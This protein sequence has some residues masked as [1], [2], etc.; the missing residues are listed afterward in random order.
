MDNAN[1][2]DKVARSVRRAVRFLREGV[3][4]DIGTHVSAPHDVLQVPRVRVYR[5][6]MEICV[7]TRWTLAIYHLVIGLIALI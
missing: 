4:V 7:R 2:R 1:F 6:H 3:V 5:G